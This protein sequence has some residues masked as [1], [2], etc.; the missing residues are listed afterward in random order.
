MD[1]GCGAG[2]ETKAMLD[3]GWD[4]TAIDGEAALRSRLFRL[5]GDH[6]A[7]RVR[8]SSFEALDIP[9]AD[10]LYAGYSLPFVPPE[11]FS[12][13]WARIRQAL[14]PGARLAVDLFGDRDDW[15]G[16][17]AMTFVSRPRVEEL[18]DG[19]QIVSIEEEDEAG[20]AHSGP[21][22]WHVFHVIARCD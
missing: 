11:E 22:H 18:L 20:R 12:A 21:K 3:N 17:R 8:V 10:L 2:V 6:P 14:R 13:L 5:V 16:Q 4:V 19:M 7:L 15:V 9:P 1:L